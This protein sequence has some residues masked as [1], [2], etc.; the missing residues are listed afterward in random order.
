M[1]RGKSFYLSIIDEIK[2][3]KSLSNISQE[4]GV[5][6]QS[7]NY[8]VSTLKT[9]RCIRKIG[10][11]TWEFLK[12]LDLNELKKVKK[13]T[14]L[15]ILEVKDIS[16]PKLKKI[17]KKNGLDKC[18]FCN[19]KE[20]HLH[21][22]KPKSK[23][24][25]DSLFNIIPVCP[26]HHDLIHKTRLDSWMKNKIEEYFNILKKLNYFKQDSVRG[27]AFQIKLELPENYRNWTNRRKV[28]DYIGM[29][30]KP[31]LIGGIDRGELVIIDG[32]K[33][34]LY[35]KTIVFNF[36]EKSFLS[37]TAKE[38]KSFVLAAFLKLV[39]K[40]ERRFNNSPMSLFGKYKFKVT[41]QHYALIKN[42]LAKQYINEKKKLHCYTGKG[43]WLLIDNSFNL[44]E[45]ET[46]HKDTAVEDNEK[47][48][49]VFNNIKKED[50]STI[51][52]MSHGNIK[53]ELTELRGVFPSMKEYNHNLKLHIKVQE[54]NLKLA[55][56]NRNFLKKL[57]EKM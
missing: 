19:F 44:E 20:I 46:L 30:W 34:H 14:E 11:G 2:K 39:K 49:E 10:Y 9:L 24:G 33:T 45:L 48:Q 26:N 37:E 27:H 31:H 22:L 43:L 38:S 23:G 1:K 32:I 21:H 18:L 13:T 5:T 7:L 12:E 29:D 56:E 47:V 15:G 50:L 54:E 52:E 3:G 53:K 51:K 6:K 40:L 28:F 17:L 42:S 8:Y 57:S 41:R 16:I 4:L 25:D 36:D 55:K 35:N